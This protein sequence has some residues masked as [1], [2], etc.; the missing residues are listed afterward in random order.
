MHIYIQI[1]K[2]TR[3]PTD[4]APGRI[5]AHPTIPLTLF[6]AALP[7][8][9]RY[10]G[11]QFHLAQTDGFSDCK[12]KQSVVLFLF[13][14]FRSE[15]FAPHALS[16]PVPCFRYGMPAF[17]LSSMSLL[18]ALLLAAVFGRASSF[19]VESP[20]PRNPNR[21]PLNETEEERRQFVQSLNQNIYQ[22]Q[23]P[24]HIRH[25]AS[26][27]PFRN[28]ASRI[29][30]IVSFGS[31][32]YITTSTSGGYIY[33]INPAGY[34]SLWMNVQERML[35][36]SGRNLN[37]D[38]AQHGGVRGVAFP[39][40]Y[41]RTGLFYVSAMEDR[42]K[43]PEN[44]KYFSGP[45]STKNPDSVVLEFRYNF[46]AGKVQ[47]GSYRTVLRIGNP[48]NDHTIKQMAFDGNLLLIGHGDGSRGSS[49]LNGGMNNDGL[50]KIFRINPLRQHLDSYRVPADNPFV[51]DARYKD[52]LYAVGL[53]NPHNI[54]VSK[55]HGTFVTDAGRDNVEEVNMLKAGANY[56]WFAR[57]GTF[58]HLQQGGTGIGIDKLPAD[59]AKYGYTYPVVQLGHLAPR[60]KSLFGQAL[61]G[62]CP[63]EN[64][65]PL[66]GIFMY[67]NFAE[68]G[69]LYYSW[70]GMMKK[71][72]T[73][74]PPNTLTQARVY[75]TSIFFDHDKNP[76]TP[77]LK[78]P[79]LRA[80]I[81]ADTTPNAR[82]VDLRFGRGPKG[83]I[84]FSSKANGRI[85]VITSTLPGA[86]I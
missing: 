46:T 61:A 18:L 26:I 44:F 60:G 56:G 29:V 42:P 50:G 85:Y 76:S 13:F 24:I 35:T 58:V 39:E 73:K 3:I 15:Q 49:P 52:E 34:V 37:C 28:Q 45:E 62:S 80:V 21:D 67:A 78:L 53:R 20:P 48:V 31:S 27:P 14:R 8:L 4:I 66:R 77:P 9:S 1:A 23:L 84:Y 75:N 10:L 40:Y 69:E 2:P 41:W 43:D 36:D 51:G 70:V 54:C 7:A 38:S 55:S 68:G 5:S 16:A 83:E 32:L 65:S 59:D 82:R 11:T 12:Y 22:G 72:V 86:P 71:A 47:A 63:I 64:S 17:K 6:K 57:E 74:G 79:N 81:R 25:F 33:R 19:E 30:G